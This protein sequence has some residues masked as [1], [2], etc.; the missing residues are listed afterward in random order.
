MWRP[1]ACDCSCSKVV[2]RLRIGVGTR[3]FLDEGKLALRGENIVVS[4][5]DCRDKVGS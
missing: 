3:A 4:T 2:L 5:G 1:V